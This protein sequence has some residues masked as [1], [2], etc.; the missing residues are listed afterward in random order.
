VRAA[1]GGPA[2][3]RPHARRSGPP[4]RRASRRRRGC[5]WRGGSRPLSPEPR[6]RRPGVL[7]GR[8]PRGARPFRSR[9]STWRP[10]RR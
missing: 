8:V 1:A 2:Q 6:S 9:P 10:A 3:G 4:G 7:P 5:G